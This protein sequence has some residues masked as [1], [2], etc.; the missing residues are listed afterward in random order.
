MSQ[1]GFTIVEILLV[2]VLL[3][4]LAAIAFPRYINLEASSTET[5]INSAVSELNNREMLTWSYTK[6]SADGYID[7]ATLQA[8]VDYYLGNEYKW[9]DLP[10]QTGGTLAFNGKNY[11]L[12]RAQSSN[13]KGGFWSR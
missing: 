4:L 9:I 10:S 7:D 2:L 6:I 1:R 11:P 5:L 12:I 13:L 3:G 8:M